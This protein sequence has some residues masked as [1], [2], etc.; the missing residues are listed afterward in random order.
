VLLQHGTTRKRAEAI[1]QNGPDP[2]Y[3]EPPGHISADGFSTA[4]ALGPFGFGRP[5]THARSKAKLFPDEG[6]PA[7]LEFEF[8]DHLAQDIIADIQN[9]IQRGKAL[10]WG[11]EIAFDV[12]HGIEQLLQLWPQL[13]KRIHF[14]EAR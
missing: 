12:G 13:N 2:R 10:N 4:P 1:L 5:E 3:A 7:I 9:P 14:P 11:D 8:P 6:G